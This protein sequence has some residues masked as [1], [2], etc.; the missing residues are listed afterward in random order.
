M[1]ESRKKTITVLFFCNHVIF[2][3]ATDINE[4][5][6]HQLQVAELIRLEVVFVQEV[7]WGKK[8]DK[9]IRN[10]LSCLYIYL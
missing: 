6:R 9:K 8:I 3:P 2:F 10:D 1:V 4:P 7:T 5:R